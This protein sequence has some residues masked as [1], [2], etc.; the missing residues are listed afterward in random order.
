MGR[1]KGGL[2]RGFCLVFSRS[3]TAKVI[4]DSCPRD[5]AT[6]VEDFAAHIRVEPDRNGSA[7]GGDRSK[8]IIQ[9]L[10]F[11]GSIARR[12]LPLETAAG[13]PAKLGKAGR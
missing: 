1:R 12:K 6:D 8:I 5:H 9:R 11:G 2:F 13:G 10:D 7:G 3:R 4:I